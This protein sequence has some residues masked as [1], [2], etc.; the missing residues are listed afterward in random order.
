[1]FDK[2]ALFIDEKLFLLYAFV[3]IFA[4]VRL[5]FSNFEKFREMEELFTK[6]TPTLLSVKVR[7]ITL[8]NTILAAILGLYTIFFAMYAYTAASQPVVLHEDIVVLFPILFFLIKIST[9]VLDKLSLIEEEKFYNETLDK[10][11]YRKSSHFKR[12]PNL[13]SEYQVH[14]PTP[15]LPTFIAFV[16]LFF[17]ITNLLRLPVIVY[18]SR[19]G[20][21]K[22]TLSNLGVQLYRITMVISIVLLIKYIPFKE[23]LT[24]IK[25]LFSFKPKDPNDVD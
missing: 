18:F 13:K 10:I 12:E 14:P 22:M 17:I 8:V 15:L 21:S 19:N 7:W 6:K 25:E 23:L 24:G 9:S 3:M 20:A 1:M 4:A 5:F 16:L 2:I 11:G